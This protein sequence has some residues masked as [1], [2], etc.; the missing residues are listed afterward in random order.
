[1]TNTEPVTPARAQPVLVTLPAEIDMANAVAAASSW[2]PRSPRSRPAGLN[3]ST[4]AA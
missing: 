2:P 1:M 4:H 3:T